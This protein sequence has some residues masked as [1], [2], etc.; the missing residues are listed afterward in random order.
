MALAV[1]NLEGNLRTWTMMP[2]ERD[3]ERV[4]RR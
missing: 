4:E 1:G 2:D 3:G